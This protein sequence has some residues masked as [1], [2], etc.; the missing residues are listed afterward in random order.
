MLPDCRTLLI[1]AFYSCVFVRKL[2]RQLVWLLGNVKY[3]LPMAPLP[4]GQQGQGW[5]SDWPQGLCIGIM[6]LG[7]RA[8]GHMVLALP[9]SSSK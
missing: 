2:H 9:L 1:L 4:R 7:G 5:E 6:K 8:A 3:L